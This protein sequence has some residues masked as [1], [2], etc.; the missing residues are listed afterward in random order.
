MKWFLHNSLVLLVVSLLNKNMMVQVCTQ[1]QISLSHFRLDCINKAKNHMAVRPAIATNHLAV[2]NVIATNQ[3]AV[4]KVI[5]SNHL[6]VRKAIASKYLAVWKVIAT[7]H[8]AIV[9]AS[10]RQAVKK[11]IAINYDQQGIGSLMST[12]VAS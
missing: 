10:N 11:V 9:T 2:R 7:N 5:A 1:M 4:R 8:L 6:A 3:L 12:N